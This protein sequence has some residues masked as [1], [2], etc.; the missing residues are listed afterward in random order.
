MGT[1]GNKDDAHFEIESS[2]AL[3]ISPTIIY[4]YS[5]I[6][7]PSMFFINSSFATDLLNEDEKSKKNTIDLE[8][9]ISALFDRNMLIVGSYTIIGCNRG[10][11]RG[12]HVQ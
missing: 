9:T 1:A 7:H 3:E 12:I 2:N 8:T 4:G 6:H 10:M 5:F 11:C